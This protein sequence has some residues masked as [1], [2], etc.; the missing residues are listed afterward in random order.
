MAQIMIASSRCSFG[1][2]STQKTL[3]EKIKKVLQEEAK[4]CLQ[5]KTL[6]KVLCAHL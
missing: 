3:H 5:A 6:Q 4:K 2:G 1:W